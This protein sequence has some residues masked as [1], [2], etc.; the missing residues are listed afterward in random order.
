MTIR[1]PVAFVSW[2]PVQGRSEEIASALGGDAKNIY[3]SWMIG[4][5][6]W[7][8]PFRYLVSFL[9]TLGYLAR[10][11]P[12]SVITTLPPVFP[13]L[14]AWLY[15]RA[16][17]AHFVLDSHPS[18]F[19]RK[20]DR[21]SERLL[22]IHRW[23]SR[24]AGA[25]M[26][27]TEEWVRHVDD[28]GGR[29]VIVHEAPALLDV[30]S[31]PSAVDPF[32][33]LLVVIFSGDEPVSEAIEAVRGLDG[34]RLR[35]TGDTR[36]CDPRLIESAPENVEFVGFLGPDDYRQAVEDAHVLIALTTEP[37]SVM[38]AAYEAV[39]AG[40]PLI[41]SDWPSIRELFGHAVLIPNTA[42]GIRQGLIV[43][44]QSFARL[45]EATSAASDDQTARWERQLAALK[46]A[47][48]IENVGTGA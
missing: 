11:R 14:A 2:S 28:W 39:Y 19:G 17:G 9:H 20:G 21:M 48:D 18:G 27:T 40:R 26:V 33:A 41:A 3:Y 7:L 35:V 15:S 4:R 46:R 43:A 31:P 1:P 22:P 12:E 23:L 6:K 16:A 29:G 13:G 38:R 36:R 8:V 37:T 5:R 42:D 47:L 10:R 25:T 32:V 30:G 34:I 44:R 45:M 24:R